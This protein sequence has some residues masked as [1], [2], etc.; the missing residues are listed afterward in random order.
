MNNRTYSARLVKAD[1]KRPLLGADF[2]REH[3]L[4]VDIC[5]KRVIEADT[6]SS[7]LCAATHASVHQLA[8]IS[9]VS[10]QHRKVLLGYQEIIQHTF[11]S[12]TVI[13]GVQYYITTSGIPVHAKARRLAPDK[14]TIAN[15]EFLEM[16]KMGSIRKSNSP[17]ACP[18]HIVPKSNGGW[19][20]CGD[21]RRLN[22][23]TTPDRYH[24]QHIQEFASQLAGKIIF[25]KIDLISGYHQ[26]HVT[27][28]DIPKTAIITPFG[29]YEYLRMSFGLKNAAQAFQ[30]LPKHQLC[31]FVYLDDI[32]IA[33]SN[34]HQ[35]I[36]DLHM[37]CGR[38]KQFGLAITFEKCIFGVSKIDFVICKMVL[39]PYLAK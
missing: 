24:I 18:L 6:Y 34:P 17:W 9:P 19:R 21:Y 22:S 14:R 4:L 26:I 3:N 10:N 23:I 28:S 37:V 27:P 15:T 29:L 25:S 30:R 39:F 11:S 1:G 5:G 35:L 32:L 36:E 33:S 16:E 31:F 7:I 12:D 13:H 8:T 20:P 2:L 38:L